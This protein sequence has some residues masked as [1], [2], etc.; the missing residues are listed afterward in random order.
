MNNAMNNY[1]R[2]MDGFTEYT[3]GVTARGE[4]Q[5]IGQRLMNS[6]RESDR[7]LYEALNGSYADCFYNDNIIHK[8][9]EF[10]SNYFFKE[11][12]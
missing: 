6:I 12:V 7:D 4:D 1:I 8:T 9:L 5:R 3:R 11:V 10:I 2:V